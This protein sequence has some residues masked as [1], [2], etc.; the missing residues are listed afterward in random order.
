MC[1]AAEYDGCGWNNYNAPKAAFLKPGDCFKVTM[2]WGDENI[3]WYNKILEIKGDFV[4]FECVYIFTTIEID[5]VTCF[6]G[7]GSTKFY[8]QITEQQYNDAKKTIKED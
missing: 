4:K 3:I 1:F 2:H 8:S 5:H 6:F 7:T